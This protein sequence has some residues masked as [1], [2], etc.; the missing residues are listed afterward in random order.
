MTKEE[1]LD[2][3]LSSKD[4]SGNTLIYDRGKLFFKLF[5]QP[6]KIRDIGRIILIENKLV[7][8]KYE[9]EDSKFTKTNAWSI[10][11]QVVDHVD[12]IIYI[13]ENSK[14]KITREEALKYGEIFHFKSSTELKLY[15]PIVYW[16]IENFYLSHTELKRDMDKEEEKRQRL[17]DKLGIEWYK[18]LSSQFDQNYMKDLS[19]EITRRRSINTVYPSPE[20]IFTAF[21]LTPYDKV[22]VVMVGQ[23][24]YHSG[25]AHGLAFSSDDPYII[26]PSLE[27]IYKE[28]ENNIYKGLLVNRPS[29]NLEGW[30]KQGVFLLNTVLTVDKGKAG[31]HKGLGWETFTDE[32][33][34]QLNKSSNRL[35]FVLWGKEAKSKISLM[36]SNFHLVL[37][38]PHPAA[39]TYVPLGGESIGFYGTKPFSKINSFLRE[40]GKEEIQ[41]V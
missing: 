9:N 15:V 30:A 38:A 32:V 37:Q 40:I 12:E 8:I 5:V 22:K 3:L 33:I 6:D 20:N 11:H 41:W 2:I 19:K 21:K 13:T 17:I 34:R 18:K 27:V 7:Y 4:K 39:E 23:C 10:I 28:L 25:V 31:S 16:T 24:P 14:Y 29:G 36:D 35:V 26:P 1:K